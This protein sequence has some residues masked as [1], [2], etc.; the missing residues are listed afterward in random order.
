M[1]FFKGD[2]ASLSFFLFLFFLGLSTRTSDLV[3]S[4]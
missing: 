4:T 2:F 3:S 1:L